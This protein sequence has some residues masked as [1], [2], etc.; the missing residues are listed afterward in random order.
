M[1][2]EFKEGDRV[3]FI[4]KYGDRVT[5]TYVKAESMPGPDGPVEGETICS[6]DSFGH[7]SKESTLCWVPKRKLKRLEV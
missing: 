4:S 6:F 3:W 5:G 7:V 1:R 2:N